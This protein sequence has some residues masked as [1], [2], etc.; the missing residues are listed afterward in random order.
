MLID[1]SKLFDPSSTP[2]VFAQQFTRD[3][4]R[5]ATNVYLDVIHDLVNEFDDAGL[6]FEPTDPDANDPDA[7][8]TLEVTMA[9]SLA[10]LV[11]HV[12]ASLEEGAAF[13]SLLARGIVIDG[14]LRYEPDWRTITTKSQVLQRIEESRRM[15]LAY[16]DT[17]P[18]QPHLDLY[19][20]FPEGSRFASVQINAPASYLFG[21]SHLA[22]HI[23]Q[24]EEAARQAREAMRMRS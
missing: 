8:T 22:G 24:F 16:L 7:K 10:H 1:F 18:D 5:V 2:S 19:R 12:T 11:L 23:A 21:M 4:L 15:S 6:T 3:H 20:K 9:W 14:R 13:S 17:W